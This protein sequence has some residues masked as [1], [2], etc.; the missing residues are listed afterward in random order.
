[1]VRFWSGHGLE[2]KHPQR[3]PN[4]IMC[5]QAMKDPYLECESLKDSQYQIH[6]DHIDFWLAVA[7]I[8]Q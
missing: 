4:F 1:M 7:M 8:D 2:I 3:E 6:L 5:L